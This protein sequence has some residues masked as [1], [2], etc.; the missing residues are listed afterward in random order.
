MRVVLFGA[1]CSGK[2]TLAR[3]LGEAYQLPVTHLDD[4]FHRPGWE[5]T[6]AD[7][8]QQIVRVIADASGW[9]IDGNYGRVRPIILSRATHIVAFDLPLRIVLWRIAYRTLGR[10]LGLRNVSRPPAQVRGEQEPILA[11][12][13]M[14]HAAVGYKRG[15][16]QRILA[17]AGEAG[18]S[19]DCVHIIRE[20]GETARVIEWLG[21]AGLR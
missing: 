8:F 5:P 13:A 14:S 12:F 1:P 6:P 16:L 19:D 18:L 11:G 9:V 3:A 7:E 4:I 10:R 17:Q 20:P 21:A 15:Q 2:S